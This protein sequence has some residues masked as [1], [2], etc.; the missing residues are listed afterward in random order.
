EDVATGTPGTRD[1]VLAAAL[2]AAI[3]SLASRFGT[4]DMTAWLEPKLR[5]TYMELGGI[6]MLFGPTTMER[7]NRGSYNLLVEVGAPGGGQIIVPPGESGALPIGALAPEPP[8][9][10]DQLR[11]YERF[12]Y[13][14]IPA[15]RGG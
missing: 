5:E 15:P 2:R 12:T 13:R 7:E 8:H 4:D 10:R 6:G 9:L 11:L 3:A 1:G 14:R